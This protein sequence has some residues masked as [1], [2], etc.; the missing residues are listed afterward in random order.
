MASQ[1]SIL[2]AWRQLCRNRCE[3][4]RHDA[5]AAGERRVILTICLPSPMLATEV[6]VALWYTMP[7]CCCWTYN[8][9]AS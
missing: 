1:S 8:A 6:A 7:C 3:C 5:S 9:K 2:A 4:V